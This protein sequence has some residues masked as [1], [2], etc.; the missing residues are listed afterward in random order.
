MSVNLAEELNYD[1][2]LEA[3]VEKTRAGKIDWQ[4]TADPDSFI[5]AVKGRQT[6]SISR[7][8]DDRVF[9]VV[10]DGKGDEIFRTPPSVTTARELFVLVQR[11]AAHLDEKVESTL[12]LVNQL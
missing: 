4:E 12:E 5:A 2:L 6:F 8:S 7:M 3:I 9:L 11:I 10:R 1:A